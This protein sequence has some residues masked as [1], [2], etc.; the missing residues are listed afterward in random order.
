MLVK[1]T[2]N[3][4]DKI[5]IDEGVVV[6]NFGLDSEKIIGPTRG[7]AEFTATPSIRDIEF[8]G[9]RGKTKGMQLKDGEDVTLK[10]ATL[11]CSK[12]NL[13]LAIPGAKITEKSG[14]TPASITPGGIG[15]ISKDSYLTNVAVVTK[16]LDSTFNV[17]V[18]DNPMHE[19]AF[20]YKA[21]SK[22]ENEHNL[23][24]LGHYDPLSDEDKIWHID[25]YDENPLA[26]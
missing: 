21:A 1:L 23:E 11:C 24:L 13:A 10:I 19:G 17:L 7:G 6:I 2:Q 16:M 9:R 20:S 14:D 8:D 4:I 5:Q 12:E 22:S 18:L 26:S 3:D 15:V 25:V